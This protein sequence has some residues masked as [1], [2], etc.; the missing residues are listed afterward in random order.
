[1]LSIPRTNPV[2]SK[3][4]ATLCCRPTIRESRQRKAMPF[5]QQV[6]I[7]DN[8][9]LRIPQREAWIAIRDHFSAPNAA[10]EIGVVLPVGCGKSGLI[11]IAPYAVG[12][13]RT[14]VIAPGTRI[15]GQLGDD[16]LSN[17]ATN[18]YERCRVLRP[19][20]NMPETVIVESGRVNRDDI[21]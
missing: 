15:R 20:D 12:A 6:S 18:F 4:L 2:A 19:S 16:L 3:R 21:Q 1:H 9:L 14:L 13:R 11:A 5:D 7:T 10:R 8:V 17:S